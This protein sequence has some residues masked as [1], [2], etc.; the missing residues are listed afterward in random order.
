MINPIPLK[1]L[2]TLYTKIFP[3]LVCL[4]TLPLTAQVRLNEAVNSNSQVKDEDGDTPDWFE[5]YNA[6]PALDL[7]GWTVSDDEEEPDKW[8]IPSL[9]IPA[10][11]Y[12]VIWASGKDRAVDFSFRNL[13]KLGDACRYLVPS[14]PVPEDWNARTFDD[15][16]W[17]AGTTPIGYGDGP[18]GSEVPGGTNAAFLRYDFTVDDLAG[19]EELLLDVDY[20]DGFV[21]Y[22][23]GQEIA[24]ANMNGKRP[25]RGATA[26]TSSEGRIARGERTERFVY[27][28]VPRALRR[29]NNVL[30][31]QVHNVSYTSSDLTLS[32]FLS[33][34]YAGQ[35]T[36]GE[37]PPEVLS[38]GAY[39]PHANFKISSRGETLY[40][41]RNNGTLVD[42]LK[43][44]GIP[45]NVSVGIPP[46]GGGARAYERTTPGGPNTT[47]GYV[48]RVNSAV[49][50]NPPSGVYG[51]TTLT[52]SGAPAR[53]TIHYSLDATVPT[54]A[55]PVY[56]GPIR[57]DNNT[58]VRARIFEGQKLPS[59]VRTESYLI[60]RSHDI[61]V[62]SLVTD[63]DAFFDENHGL[64]AWGNGAD[65]NPPYYGANYWR[66]EEVPG[67]FSFFPTDGGEGITQDIG[68]KIF[69]G[70]SRINA[71]RSLSIFARDRYGGDDLD[72]PFFENRPYEAFTS[73]VLRNSGGDWMRTMIRDASMTEIMDGSGLD[74]QAHRPVATYINGDYWG[75]YN[76]REKV[77]EDF[78]ASR[79]GVNPDSVDIL[80]R[81]GTVIEGNNEDYLAM[82]AFV[83][84]N[85]LANDANYQRVAGEMDIDN[86]IKY[87][88]AQIFYGNTDW[89]A[90]NIKYWKAQRPGAKWRWILFDTDFGMD[91]YDNNPPSTDGIAFAFAA[92]GPEYPNSPASTELVRGLL[93]NREFQNR[94]INQFADELN[95]RFLY[96]SIDCI[97]TKN[98]KRIE[99]E[100]PLSYRRWQYPER[101]GE[102]VDRMRFY[103]RERP[104]FI[105]QHIMDYFNLGAVHQ[106]TV[107]LDDPTEGYV[108]LNSL[109]I[110]AENWAGDY[111]EEIPIRLEAI[112]NEGYEFSHWTL[113]SEAMT[114][115]I[116][117]D[118][119]QPATFRPVFRRE[120]TAVGPGGGMD[121]L[122]TIKDLVCFPNPASRVAHL[123]FTAKCGTRASARLYDV[124]GLLV[125]TFVDGYI[126]AGPQ[127]FSADVSQLPA[128]VYQLRVM[129]N[130]VKSGTIAWVIH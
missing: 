69:G 105:K 97:V 53:G 35:S 60:D 58:V 66:D 75:L 55:S 85:D 74:V 14:G 8:T 117:V 1:P 40:L 50:F 27:A 88:A 111:F 82:M 99:R 25:D 124:R 84:G 112:P 114:A 116:I 16:T 57:I 95:S 23:N 72:Y 90:G 59:A 101:L 67:Q 106:T 89:P 51:Q 32:A 38:F 49:T 65:D 62:V 104:A 77:N 126:P 68:I 128:G 36:E 10:G 107:L 34:R 61:D 129:E 45:A 20:D 64:Y 79:H 42:Q 6:G 41:F 24:R 87:Q 127:K 83:R 73:L 31:I 94:F 71:Q 93:A 78:L 44:E 80:E 22:L 86:Y 11:G 52:L 4:L 56:D 15:E 92:D 109:T 37:A 54:A 9:T 28:D 33:A 108:Q 12:Q 48:G 21:A 123:A 113:G 63:P 18:Y 70:W 120:T 19:V 2:Y 102:Y 76:L 118:V 29:G 119:R 91:I 5:I 26:T 81:F 98:E 110:R 96:D 7:T 100:M 103:Y 125:R 122:Q 30:A 130:G 3:L 13:V 121:D 43:V 17:T 115:E 39:G 46:G 47:T